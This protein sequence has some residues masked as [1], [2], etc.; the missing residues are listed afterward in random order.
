MVYVQ[1]GTRQGAAKPDPTAGLAA[2]SGTYCSHV[3]TTI[4]GQTAL[5]RPGDERKSMRLTMQNQQVDNFDGTAFCITPDNNFDAKIKGSPVDTL[6]MTYLHF[7]VINNNAAGGNSITMMHPAAFFNRYEV[8]ANGGSTDDT[9]YDGQ[10]YQDFFDYLANDQERMAY[11]LFLHTERAAPVTDN[12]LNPANWTSFDESANAIAPQTQKEYWW[13]ILCFLTTTSLW[14]NTKK[15]DPTVR[16]YGNV[17]PILSS[18]NAL[19]IATTHIG[20]KQMEMYH[21]GIKFMPAVRAAI[22]DHILAGPLMMR[23]LSH[24]RQQQAIASVA[25]LTYLTDIQLTPISGEYAKLL[26][27]VNRND[28]TRE[29]GIYGCNRTYAAATSSPLQMANITFNDSSGTP[30]FF[31]DVHSDFVR[32][33]EASLTTSALMRQTK[34]YYPL[35]FCTNPDETLRSGRSTGGL[36]LD[37]NFTFKFQLAPF[38]AGATTSVNFT[39]YGSRYSIL[40]AW[41][42]GNFE[43]IRL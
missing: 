6:L 23:T 8:M 31:N 3:K 13:P 34:N 2:P 1:S 39:C 30:V 24:D 22:N 20:F 40:T 16:V 28:C 32:L 25:Q 33:L 36:T 38:T 35:I 37:G 11:S 21:F 29:G 42:N 5:V 14:L 9:I 19:D 26:M 7:Y 10:I 27:F 43:L 15:V 4:H 41:P 12:G 17:N 18:N